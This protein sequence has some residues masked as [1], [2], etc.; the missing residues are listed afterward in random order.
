[1]YV[2]FESPLQMLADSPSNYRKEPDSLAFLSA[3][4]VVW[5]ETR[6]LGAKVGE[7]IL[8]AR[9]SGRE[10]YVAALTNWES[11]DLDVELAFL[12]KGSFEAD[13]YRDGPN[14]DRVGVDYARE[15]RPVGAGDRLRLHLAPGGGAVVRITPK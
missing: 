3:V 2:V 6:V 12:G 5:D 13:V 7:H 9:R 4:P 15:R 8:V 11:R 1:M 14:A 10:W